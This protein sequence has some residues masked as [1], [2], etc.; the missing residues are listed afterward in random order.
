LGQL[1]LS[2]YFSTNHQPE[3]G[4]LILVHITMERRFKRWLVP[5]S[6]YFQ[7]EW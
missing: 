1:P 4:P 3:T 7:F 2:Q 5:F 6:S